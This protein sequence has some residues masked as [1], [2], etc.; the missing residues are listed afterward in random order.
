MK[1][2]TPLLPA[3]IKHHTA[4]HKMRSMRK[5]MGS[6]WQEHLRDMKMTE[7]EMVRSF[8]QPAGPQ[9][10]W[11]EIEMDQVKS[12]GP[13][14]SRPILCLRAEPGVPLEQWKIIPRDQPISLFED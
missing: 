5:F 9:R 4:L 14:L 13:H 2:H 12:L 7:K 8:L 3:S 6:D 11:Y 1:Y 10:S